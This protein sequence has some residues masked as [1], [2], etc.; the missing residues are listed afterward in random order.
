[1]NVRTL[2]PRIRGARQSE[3]LCIFK[4]ISMQEVVISNASINLTQET[5]LTSTLHDL[6]K[7]QNPSNMN[8]VMQQNEYICHGKNTNI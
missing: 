2:R 5:A 8:Y 7:Q 3:P 6:C 1:M 4:P